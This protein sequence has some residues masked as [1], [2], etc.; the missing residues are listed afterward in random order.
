MSICAATSH[1]SS[2]GF[3]SC[4]LAQLQVM[5]PTEA[6]SHVPLR[7]LSLVLSY[8]FESC[9]SHGF[10]SC[11]PH[12][13][14]WPP[15]LAALFTHRHLAPYKA[16]A[17]ILQK[18][19]VL[20]QKGRSGRR[21]RKGVEMSVEAGRWGEECACGRRVRRA[22]RALSA[23]HAHRGPSGS[24]GLASAR[25]GCLR[26]NPRTHKAPLRHNTGTRSSS[27]ISSHPTPQRQTR[28]RKSPL[29]SLERDE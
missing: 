23:A 5:S 26:P 18:E 22:R 9:P 27:P 17:D 1:V 3:E 7:G 28:F 15:S 8:G 25:P 4:P 2:Y 19:T 14:P 16:K 11:P 13:R 10:E 12:L 29:V 21:G 24:G 20:L 6:S